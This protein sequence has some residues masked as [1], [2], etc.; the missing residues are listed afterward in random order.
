[1]TNCWKI[2]KYTL[3]RSV[4]WWKL[5]YV[6]TCTARWHVFYIRNRHISVSSFVYKYDQW[7]H[8]SHM[9]GRAGVWETS[10]V[11]T[12][13]KVVIFKHSVILFRC[14]MICKWPEP[15]NL[16]TSHFRIL[17][18]FPSRIS[19]LFL[20]HT[21]TYDAILLICAKADSLIGNTIFVFVYT[22]SSIMLWVSVL[23]STFRYSD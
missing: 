20:L 17:Y 4:P 12:I 23:L 5:N 14:S 21:K 2:L 22:C 10:K 8:D 1:L 7:P 6:V 18:T 13:L 11:N 19:A 16:K 3:E 15:W 9:T